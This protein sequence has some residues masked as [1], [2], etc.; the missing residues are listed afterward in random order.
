[1][2]LI[3]YFCSQFLSFDVPMQISLKFLSTKSGKSVS[4]KIENKTYTFN[5]FEG[6]QRYCIQEHLSLASIDT[7]FLTSKY[8]IPGFIGMY[9]TL[10]ESAKTSLNIVS[11]FDVCFNKMYKHA[12][13]PILALNFLS[14]FKDK[15]ISVESVVINGVSNYIVKLPEIKGKLHP[16][17]IPAHIPKKLYKKLISDG[18]LEFEGDLYNLSDF[19]DHSIKLN[20]ICF[21]FSEIGTNIVELEEIISKADCFICFTKTSFDYFSQKKT[22]IEQTLDNFNGVHYVNENNFVEYRDFYDDQLKANEKDSRFL[23]PVSNIKAE[24]KLLEQSSNLRIIETGDQI[25]F[26]KNKGL[27]LVKRDNVLPIHSEY[28]PSY[29][30][31]E[32]LGTGC[33]IPSKDKNVSGILYQNEKSAIIMDCGEDTMSQI[34]RLHGS[35]DVLRKLKV[36]Y[37]SHS[38]ADHMLGIASIVKN[39]ENS[40]LIISPYDMKNYLEYFGN[41][42]EVIDGISDVKLHSSKS[43]RIY[44]ITTNFLKPIEERFYRNASEEQ[45]DWDEYVYKFKFDEFRFT[46]CGCIHSKTS[47][48]I[49]IEDEVS[50]KSFSYSGDTIPSPLF[51]YISKNND[52]MI[53]ESTFEDENI[54]QARKTCHTLRNEAIKCFEMSGSKFL[55]LTHF[56]NRNRESELDEYNVR[57]FFRF[58]FE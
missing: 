9:L 3:Q 1:M 38:H 49:N 19:A 36:I 39:I 7:V 56:S 23:I 30:C 4:L 44:M 46:I 2:C 27:S 6:F 43:K 32:F 11:D 20:T 48:S 25:M 57:D 41:E 52:L 14:S 12:V 28:N 21:F 50:S 15:Y 22:N 24:D 40:L 51:S 16:E 34:E 45:L 13:S 35:K 33:A 17:K 54:E 26:D 47:V 37:I 18:F 42:V 5:I 55:L 8:N 10:C 58:T 53:H 29:P 31:V